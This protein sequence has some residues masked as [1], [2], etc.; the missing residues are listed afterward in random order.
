MYGLTASQIK[1]RF[2]IGEVIAALAVAL[3]V[4]LVIYD[5]YPA[6]QVLISVP[7]AFLVLGPAVV[8]WIINWNNRPLRFSTMF[9]PVKWFASIGWSCKS[10]VCGYRAIFWAMGQ[11]GEK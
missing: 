7:I 9:N 6:D 5:S 2:I 4:W 10:I 11:K 3:N 8:G 1:T